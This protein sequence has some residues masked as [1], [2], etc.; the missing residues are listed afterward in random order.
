MVNKEIELKLSLPRSSAD[1][2]PAKVGN[3]LGITDAAQF[4]KLK[5]IYFDTPDRWLKSRGMALRIRKIGKRQI[6]TLKVPISPLDGLNSFQEFDAEIKTKCP[7]ANA[8]DDVK[9]RRHFEK[10]RIF[11][12]L[13]PLFTTIFERSTWLIK[14]GNSEI[15]L[16]LDKGEIRGQTIFSPI[17]EIEL[18]LKTGDPID[19]YTCAEYLAENLSVRLGYYT[20]AAR[21]YELIE[22][23]Q[24]I[25]VRALPLK[26]SRKSKTD[27]IFVALARS[28]LAQLRANEAVIEQSDDDEAIHQFRVAIRRF[29]VGI[30]IFRGL[31]DDDACTAMS[32]DMRWLQRQFNLVRDLDVLITD[33]LLPMQVRLHDQKWL[34]VLIEIAQTARIEARHNAQ[35][36][37]E[38]PRYTIMLLQ[39]YRQLMTSEWRSKNRDARTLLNKSAR[40]FSHTWLTRTH[41][42]LI[43]L[44][45]KYASL[46]E[47]DL[48]RLRLLTKKMRYGA[49]VFATLYRGKKT[50]KY[51][52]H[53][54]T[55]QD[56]LGS[57]NDAVVGHHL[58]IGL[59]AKLSE[60][61]SISPKEAGRLEGIILGWQSKHIAHDLSGFCRTWQA[62]KEQKKFWVES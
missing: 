30:N 44:G 62:F 36:A 23:K 18:E 52:F 7:I 61:F 31:I 5:N 21:G 4:Q 2:H 6:Q 60:K 47:V 15:E 46:S 43:R 58:L 38:N 40:D 11:E 56:Q 14:H 20:K 48:H 39:I 28:C 55:I 10:E 32:I 57:L 50:Q 24:A 33:S 25:A 16:A 22:S 3:L 49:Q 53:L 8:I 51:L 1:L 13:R 29:R 34:G 12:K 42:R 9:L 37:L 26:F 59:M 27:D 45:N 54:S 35:L 19:L 17:R 41:K